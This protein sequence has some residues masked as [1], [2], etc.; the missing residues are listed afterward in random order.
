MERYITQ[1]FG[2]RYQY[3]WFVANF[4]LCIIFS[5]SLSFSLS[6]IHVIAQPRYSQYTAMI[7]TLLMVSETIQGISINFHFP[8][9]LFAEPVTSPTHTHTAQQKREQE[10]NGMEMANK[11]ILHKKKL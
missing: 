8:R 1:V 2:K 5:L 6:H 7:L 3:F 10:R 4:T 9:N 11:L